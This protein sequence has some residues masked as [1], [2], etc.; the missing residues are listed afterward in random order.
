MQLNALVSIV[1]FGQCSDGQGEAVH[2]MRSKLS[3]RKLAA[4][5]RKAAASRLV[6]LF[7]IS[8]T[9]SLDTVP[10]MHPIT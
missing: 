8:T 4:A 10:I 2:S 9:P 5:S 7:V 1:N 6:H 3:N